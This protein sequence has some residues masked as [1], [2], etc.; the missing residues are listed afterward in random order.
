M[1]DDGIALI[2]GNSFVF[3]NAWPP[4]IHT[5]GINE[6]KMVN[7]FQTYWSNFAISGSPNKPS[8]PTLQWSTFNWNGQ[9][10]SVIIQPFPERPISIPH[11]HNRFGY[12]AGR[13]CRTANH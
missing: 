7:I 12:G 9:R 8:P 10:N 2:I 5:F 6:L 1:F 13:Y 3:G 4:I 11:S